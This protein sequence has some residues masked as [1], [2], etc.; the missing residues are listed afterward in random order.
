MPS[1]RL[2]NEIEESNNENITNKP[3]IIT[4][5]IKTNNDTKIVYIIVSI[6]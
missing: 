6:L 1:S 3:F 4:L 2:A 5:I